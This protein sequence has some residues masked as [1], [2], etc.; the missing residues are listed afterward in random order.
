MKFF[1]YIFV[2]FFFLPLF[3]TAQTGIGQWRTHLPY[4]QVIDVALTPAMV[5]AATPY[6]L[7]TYRL[8]DDKVSVFDKVKG[9]NDLGIS[10]IAYDKKSGQLLVAYTDANV[11]LIDDKQNVTNIPDI[12]NKEMP[13]LK[14]IHNIFFKDN[15]AYLSCSFG[16]VVVNMKKHEIRDTYYIG[17]DGSPLNVLNMTANDTALFAAT[18]KGIYYC[19]LNASNPADY[20]QWHLETRLPVPQQKYNLIAAFQGKIYANYYNGGWDGDTLYVFNGKQWLYFLPSN[21]SRHFQLNAQGDALLIVNRYWVEGFDA[22]GNKVFYVNK[23]EE[24]GIEPLAAAGNVKNDVWVGTKHQGLLRTRNQNNQQQLVKIDG[25]ASIKVFDLD[26]RGKNVWVVPGGYQS[27]WAK[28]WIHDGVFHFRDGI[29]EML[30][31]RNTPAFDT[32]SDP[33]CVKAD[34]DDPETAYVGTFQT[35]IMKFQKDKLVGIF[36]KNNSS[37]QPWVANPA[38]VNVSGLDF[39][40]SHN[41]WVANTGAPELLSVMKNN[42]SWKSFNLGYSLSGIDVG[43]LMVDKNNDIW[44]KKRN[45]GMVIVFNY[46]GTVDNTSDDHVRV[47]NSSR[48]NGNIQGSAV[49]SF[50]TDN[51]GQVWVGTDKGIN[52]FYSPEN[53]FEPGADFD[54]QQILV[55]R[56]DGSGLADILLVTETVTAIAVDG[57]NRKWVGTQRA[58]VFLFSPDGL[59]EIHHFTTENSP[60]LSNHITGITIDKDGEVFI[61]TAKGLI[62]YRGTATPGHETFSDVYAFPNPVRENYTGPIAI[63]G[64][65]TNADV[66]ITD[67]YGNLVYETKAE[68]GQAVWDGCNFHHVHVASGVYLVFMTNADGTESLVTKILVMH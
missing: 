37:L 38:L 39:D 16:I 61:G 52:V 56:N 22:S 28:T 65:V 51:D 30:D 64:L 58:G 54:A 27:N 25:P 49:Y 57:G 8:K 47:L 13:G 26:A 10:K 14:T 32:I 50:A 68:G 31:N 44:I 29:W 33:V 17:P 23:A 62:S 36:S 19:N 42:G 46:N 7:F 1:K 11:D 59:K 24:N 43:K 21:H 67:T 63:K 55:P 6:S 53:I 5:Y 20:H 2:F 3:S 4:D 41:L 48:G 18:D 12:F 40:D 9:L 34:P 45:N 66:K 60:L 35:G 15:F